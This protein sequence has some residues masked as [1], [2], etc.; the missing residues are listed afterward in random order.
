MDEDED[1][2]SA[3][4]ARVEL[5]KEDFSLLIEAGFIAIKQL[6]ELSATRLFQAAQELSPH[7]TA[8]LIGI[9]YIALN[10]LE[11]K[12]A[13]EYFEKVVAIEPENTLAQTF[14]GMSFL[15]S[16][17][18]QKKGE[19][20]IQQAM[21]KATDPTVKNLGVIALE[22]SKKDLSKKNKIPFFASQKDED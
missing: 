5:F 18:K 11:I 15:L 13:I 3:H 12:K 4:E 7:S 8:P 14:L 9:G 22:W 6:D 1:K 17:N 19:A 20:L 2:K 10:K 16:K 21:E